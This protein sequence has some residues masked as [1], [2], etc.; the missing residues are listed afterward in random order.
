M[1]IAQKRLQRQIASDANML[2]MRRSGKP[3]FTIIN[4]PGDLPCD[5]DD[6]AFVGRSKSGGNANPVE[7]QEVKSATRADMTPS[8]IPSKV[9][10]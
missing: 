6:P 4:D 10:S 9:A 1:T 2:R 3:W 5:P 8:P 7:G